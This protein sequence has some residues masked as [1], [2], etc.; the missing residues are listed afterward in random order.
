MFIANGS[1]I[2]QDGVRR[3]EINIE[4]SSSS[5]V[6]PSEPRGLIKAITYLANPFSRAR[7]YGDV[8]AQLRLRRRM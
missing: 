3:A 6:P 1:M 4:E 2:I 8:S 5:F 7:V